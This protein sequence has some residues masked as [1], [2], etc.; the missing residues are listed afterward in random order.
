MNKFRILF[1][2]GLGMVTLPI[3]M[4]IFAYIWHIGSNRVEKSLLRKDGE[5]IH[6]T[7]EIKKTVVDTIRIKVY[8]KV[9][10]IDTKRLDLQPAP[11]KDTLK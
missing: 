11:T 7:V 2:F 6:D 5:V 10:Q 9:P 8:E 1:I 4:V 3:T